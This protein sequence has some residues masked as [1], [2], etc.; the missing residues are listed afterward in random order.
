MGKISCD[1]FLNTSENPFTFQLKILNSA[2][3]KTNY[4]VAVV[5]ENLACDSKDIFIYGEQTFPDYL[6]GLYP[7]EKLHFMGTKKNHSSG[8]F[9][10]K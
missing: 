6:D 7:D 5:T 4:T 9:T 8:Q 1:A 3:N 2:N 10:N